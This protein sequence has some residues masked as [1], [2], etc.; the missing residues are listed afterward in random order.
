[1]PEKY[2]YKDKVLQRK[3]VEDAAKQSGMDIDTYYQKA[4]LQRVNDN[5]NF[6]GK[7]VPAE[8]IFEA[9]KQSKLGFDD[10]LQKAKIVPIEDV[11]KKELSPSPSLGGQ[12]P[13]QNNQAPA[14]VEAVVEDP[15]AMAFDADR[16]GKQTVST[17]VRNELG[18]TEDTPDLEAVK[19]SGEKKKYLKDTYGVDAD[20]IVKDF[21]DLPESIYTVQGFT[22]PEL[23]EDYKSNPQLY[24]R[25]IATAKW[26]SQL[27]NKLQELP[28]G[29]KE[30]SNLMQYMDVNVGEGD[31]E[32]Q[33]GTIKHVMETIDKYGGDKKEEIIR[34]AGIDFSKTYGE[35]AIDDKF[36]SDNAGGKL[37]NLQ[38]ASIKYLQD[39]HPQELRKYSA[40]LIDDE[41]IKD[42]ETAKLAKEEALKRLEE[43]GIGLSK[44]YL[45]EKLNPIKKEYE[46]ILNG[47]NGVSSTPEEMQRLRELE[48]LGS[49]YQTKLENINED[50]RV[51]G[52]KYPTA[53]AYD[54]RNF[55]QELIGQRNW[56]GK[57]LLLK[58]G[59]ATSNTGKGVYDFVA[60]PFR[61]EEGSQLRQAEILGEGMQNR[62]STYMSGIGG[63]PELSDELKAEVEKIKKDDSLS[64]DQKL[65]ATTQLLVKR[66][67]EWYTNNKESNFGLKSLA[68]GI[69]DLAA[70][71]VPFMAAEMLTGGGATAGFTRKFTSTF[72]SAAATSFED[73]YRNALERGEKN[74]Y[75]YA[76]RVTA[77][78][79]AA[80][81][82]AGTPDKIRAIFAKQ[83]S[84]IGDLVNKMTDKEIEAVLKET[85][86]AFKNFKSTLNA[87]KEKS[88]SAA[89][90]TFSSFKDAAKINTFM[91]GGQIANDAISGEL[92][93]P[94]EYIKDFAI[95]TLKFGLLSTMGKAATKLVKP[96]DMG[97]SSLYEV[98]T[99][100]DALL[101]HLD[102]QIKDGIIEPEKAQEVRKNIEDVSKIY[103]KNQ[104]VISV[105]FDKQKREYLYN[106]LMEERNSKLAKSLPE[107]QAEK[108]EIEAEVAKQKNALLL[109]PKTKKQLLAQ[110]VKAEKSLIPE[111][112]AEGKNIEIPQKEII[113]AKA[114]IQAIDEVLGDIKKANE[115]G[116]TIDA[117]TQPLPN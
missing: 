10:Y 25:K 91:S 42:N 30:W 18:R 89:K 13:A 74:P 52:E 55:A 115:S 61:S 16:L 65:R 70:G 60:E 103:N 29:S 68:Y 1:M 69:T 83:K 58:T 53:S 97:L 62:A 49:Q 4:G 95:E 96:T 48:Q 8:E 44:S 27:K 111:K 102:Q 45:E 33:R 51:L 43:I 67:G 15:I 9:A 86:S 34:N 50:E 76:T 14:P 93:R 117:P 107:K 47:G 104:E 35:M 90:G 78:S 54:A 101:T 73:S 59:E 46:A 3:E 116:V 40:A 56:W 41:F 84:P 6:N 105:L 113:A 21:T 23:I 71:L 24:E 31:Y 75:A 112:D 5:Y 39:I 26:Q 11:K 2:L 88:V 85:P 109:E 20:K 114:E 38:S 32:Q 72:V 79:S 22:K 106:A 98:A 7:T 37:N 81:A 108:Y 64:Y 66:N 17:S 82:G 12:L 99:N 87:M 19:L 36:I 28:E 57:H 94:D 92:R 63:K 110:K 80:I 77:I 100:K